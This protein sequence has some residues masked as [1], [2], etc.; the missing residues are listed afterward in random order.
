VIFGIFKTFK[1]LK[2][3]VKIYI[4]NEKTELAMV[5]GKKGE[6]FFL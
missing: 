4:N 2:S 6:A 1:S 3:I 5:L